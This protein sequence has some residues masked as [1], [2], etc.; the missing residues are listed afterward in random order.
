MKMQI[1]KIHVTNSVTD[2][3]HGNFF[4]VYEGFVPDIGLTIN[5]VTHFVNDESNGRGRYDKKTCDKKSHCD[6]SPMCKCPDPQL[7]CEIELSNDQ[8]EDLQRLASPER[9]ETR[10]RKLIAETLEEQKIDNSDYKDILDQ[11]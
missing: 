1:W 11:L 8:I 2:M 9:P 6:K 5:H 4:S 7:I 3:V 10:I